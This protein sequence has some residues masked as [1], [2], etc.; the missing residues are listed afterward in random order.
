MKIKFDIEA[1]PQELRS[2]FGLP[3]VEPIQDEMVEMVRRH[4][5]MENFDP[6]AFMKPWLPANMQSL[7]TMQKAFWQVMAEQAKHGMNMNIPTGKDK[8]TQK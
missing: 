2:F 1:T 5:N 3:N 7:E 4:M 8:S 6:V